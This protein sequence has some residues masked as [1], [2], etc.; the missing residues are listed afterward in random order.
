MAKIRFY[1]NPQSNGTAQIIAALQ[2]GTGTPPTKYTGYTIPSNKLKT[3]YKY[4]NKKDQQV[5][6]VAN[7]DEINKKINDWKTIFNTYITDCNVAKEAP[8]MLYIKQHLEGTYISLNKR[9]KNS[10][11]VIALIDY[12][13]SQI[14]ITHDPKTHSAYMVIKNNIET[15]EKDKKKTF[16]LSDIDGKFYKDFAMWMLSDQDNINS[17]INRK[18]TRLAT[19]LRMAVKDQKIK[20]D[21]EYTEKY[22]LKEG[23]AN[24]FP[25]TNEE[26]HTLR[27]YTPD[28]QYRQM[29]LDA[30]L[31]ACETGLR[32]SDIMQLSSHHLKSQVLPEGE[33]IR[34]I[35]LSNVKGSD[36]NNMPLS[37]HGAAIVDK[38]NVDPDKHLFQFHYSQTASK[39]LKVIFENAKLT[40][41]CEVITIQGS[42][43]NRETF[44]L[45]EVISFHTGRNTYITRLLRGNV[46]PVHVQRNAGHSD[47]KMTMGYFRTDDII[48]FQ[49][50]L[51]VLNK[52]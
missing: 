6:G 4:W 24:K 8:D 5:K 9:N 3:E 45:H 19:L 41:I 50:T 29:V 25:L 36:M 11:T 15:Y 49:E 52:N 30:F 26:L 14:K 38:Y 37:D 27:N 21:A 32:H 40:R 12:A 39:T 33:I 46:A 48:R 18:Q 2:S 47:I 51:K 13:L 16:H 1:L 23:D 31:L 43:T 7:A 34:Y 35:D 28:T 20:T 22:K 10:H 42:K 44:P 17:T